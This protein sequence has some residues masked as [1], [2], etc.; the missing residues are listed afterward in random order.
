MQEQQS[1]T[2][3][4]C[5]GYYRGTCAPVAHEICFT[6]FV[7]NVFTARLRAVIRSYKYIVSD[8][9]T[10]FWIIIILVNCKLLYIDSSTWII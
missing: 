6:K 5:A 9:A 4:I 1:F 8:L 10:Q 2:T 3:V 7:T